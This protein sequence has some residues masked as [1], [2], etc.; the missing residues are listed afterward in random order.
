[1]LGTSLSQPLIR[2]DKPMYQKT[3]LGNGVKIV[4]E[5]IPHVHSISLGIWII[6]G[7]RDEDLSH[8]GVT[9]F[10]EHMFFKGTP[11]R[12]AFDISKEID[13]VGG[14]LNALTSKEYT[15]IYAK[16]LDKNIDVA[17]EMLLDLFFNSVFSPQEIERE[18]EVIAQEIHLAE[19]IPDEHIQEL[20]SKSYFKDHPLAQPILGNVATVGSL[21]RDTLL[22]FFHRHHYQP[23]KIIIAAAGN[24]D[25]HYLV[26]KCSAHY[27]SIAQHTVVS[28]RNSHTPFSNFFIHTKE[29]EQVHLCIGTKGISHT[30]PLRYA[31]YVLTTI[32]GGSM[33][34]RLFQEIREKKGLAYAVYSYFSS[35]FDAGLF[36]VY[37]GV[38]KKT[39][40]EA[41]RVVIEEL[42]T[43]KDKPIDDSELHTAQEH[44]KGTTLLASESVDHRMTRLAKCE[45]Y[46][47]KFIPLEEILREIDEVT[48]HDV[49]TLARDIFD[50]KYL[51]LAALGPLTH[52]DL[53]PD[54]LDS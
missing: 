25:H 28:S 31:G 34:S 8:N 16:V 11:T 26:E 53:S 50:R 5:R 41:V 3:V 52:D 40:E 39:V 43:L 6:T 7:S 19:D 27:G 21:S 15:G 2:T 13:S 46:F 48:P 12:S 29:L 51:S 17:L 20:L 45:M 32:L 30:H 24:L 14:L 1:M 9:H 22:A 54:I 10:I 33:S 23:S 36:T 38:N 35:Y 49:Q 47:N 37:L 4:T 18:R 44:L 42:T